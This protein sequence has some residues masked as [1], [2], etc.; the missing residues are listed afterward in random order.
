MPF[1]RREKIDEEEEE[2]EKEVAVVGPPAGGLRKKA[3]SGGGGRVRTG[4]M[5]GSVVVPARGNVGPTQFRRGPG[6]EKWLRS[7][8]P[9]TGGEGGRERRV[10][11]KGMSVRTGTPGCRSFDGSIS[12]MSVKSRR[13]VV[14]RNDIGSGSGCVSESLENPLVSLECF[15]FL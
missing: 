8:S 11:G 7:R 10:V 5:R 1:R 14:E 12:N 15:I 9:A 6:E 4:E 2:E 3:F 13:V